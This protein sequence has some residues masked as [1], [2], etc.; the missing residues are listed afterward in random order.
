M[1][2][3]PSLNDVLRMFAL[4][5]AFPARRGLGILALIRYGRGLRDVEGRLIPMK[6]YSKWI[7]V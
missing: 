5:G 4:A 7:A 6:R 1:P 2:P 3:A